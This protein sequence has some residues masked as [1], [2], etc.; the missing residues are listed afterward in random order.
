MKLLFRPPSHF[1]TLFWKA[2]LYLHAV[3][4]DRQMS[5]EDAATIIELWSRHFG[6]LCE[7]GLVSV[8]CAGASCPTGR[9]TYEGHSTLSANLR[10]AVK[11]R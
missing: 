10:T 9:Q 7:S 11:W 1:P 4:S 3:S 6:G 2:Q 8:H 5:G